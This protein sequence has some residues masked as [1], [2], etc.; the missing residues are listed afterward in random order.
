M[1]VILIITSFDWLR[2]FVS[3]VIIRLGSVC[4][5]NNDLQMVEFQHYLIA[6][7]DYV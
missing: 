1:Q 4:D 3:F 6:L 2:G 7:S 5:Q